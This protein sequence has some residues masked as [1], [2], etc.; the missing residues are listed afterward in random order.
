MCEKCGEEAP[1]AV[2]PRVGGESQLTEAAEIAA[3]VPETCEPAV[4]KPR[5]VKSH[6]AL[7]VATTIIF[8]NWALGIPAI[9]F[10]HEC[11]IAEKNGQNEIAERF[12]RR[13]MTFLCVGSALSLSLAAFLA[14]VLFIAYNSILSA[15][16]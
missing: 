9:V 12:S 10:A 3:G 14:L 11:R 7:A 8:G 15:P 4:I 6:M 1:D 16:L 2:S 5:L 13:A